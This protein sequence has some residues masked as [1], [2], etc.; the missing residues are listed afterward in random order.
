[1]QESFESP[2]I[3]YSWEE[4]DIFDGECCMLHSQLTKIV[5]AAVDTTREYSADCGCNKCVTILN[6][7]KR[8]VQLSETD[9]TNEGKGTIAF[10]S[11]E[12][13]SFRDEEIEQYPPEL[14]GLY[15]AAKAITAPLI[16]TMKVATVKAREYLRCIHIQDRSF[17]IVPSVLEDTVEVLKSWGQAS[18]CS[19]PRKKSRGGQIPLDVRGQ[20]RRT[21]ET[22]DL[23]VRY[24]NLVFDVMELRYLPHPSI[25]SGCKSVRNYANLTYLSNEFNGLRSRKSSVLDNWLQRMLKEVRAEEEDIPCL[26]MLVKYPVRYV[27]FR[28]IGYSV[29]GESAC[30]AD[31]LRIAHG[32]E[33]TYEL[34][35]R[36]HRVLCNGRDLPAFSNLSTLIGQTLVSFAARGPWEVNPD[37]AVLY[38]L[39]Y[40]LALRRSTEILVPGVLF[41]AVV[42]LVLP[43]SHEERQTVWKLN[44]NSEWQIYQSGHSIEISAE[45]FPSLKYP[46]L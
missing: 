18:V 5:A 28:Y 46:N 8:I 45:P 42:S 25:G 44:E 36:Y 15:T 39:N 1:M 30:T 21:F 3:S 11:E 12:F 23:A 24:H 38:C 40:P 2:E 22:R 33:S 19:F 9:D 26:R 35:N 29:G 6:L 10:S 34:L 41:F 43:A 27:Q 32:V 20:A 4:F 7:F 14:K 31:L 37:V 17:G 13:T 16:D